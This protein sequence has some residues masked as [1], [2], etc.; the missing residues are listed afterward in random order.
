MAP[1]L[2]CGQATFSHRLAGAS[3]LRSSIRTAMGQGAKACGGPRALAHCYARS[4]RENHR[5]DSTRHWMKVRGN[6]KGRPAQ[7]GVYSPT[8]TEAEE[9]SLRITLAAL[10]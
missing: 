9:Q 10:I 6:L 5:P 8:M 4:D 7:S 3:R 1:R 2:Q